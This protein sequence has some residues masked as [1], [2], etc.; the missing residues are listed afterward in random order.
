MLFVKM[1]GAA[2]Q[3]MRPTPGPGMAATKM[4]APMTGIIKRGAFL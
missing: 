1:A 4:M 3:G 2:G